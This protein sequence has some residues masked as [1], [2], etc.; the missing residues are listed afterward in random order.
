MQASER[1]ILSDPDWGELEQQETEMGL[2]AKSTGEDF[3]QHPSGT[4]IGRCYG[5]VDLGT[6]DG[7]Q[8]GP[9]HQCLIIWEST[10]LMED[11]RPFSLSKYYTVSL[12]EKANLYGDLVA[13]RGR[14]FTPEELDAFNVQNVIG[15][16]VMLT[17]IHNDK[18]KARVANV[19][20]IM[21]GAP[22]PE[23][24]NQTLKFSFEDKDEIPGHM[25]EWMQKMVHAA[26]EYNGAP[27]ANDAKES[28]LGAADFDDEIP[29]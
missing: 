9:K 22:V 21:K 3:P 29:F 19:A 11:G 1:A 17:V 28:G 20:K 23:P 18:G 4:T 12:N 14:D 10:E 24:V 15:A 13:W 2:T 26:P 8:F 16:P 6:Q 7:G 27:P 5:V 25:P